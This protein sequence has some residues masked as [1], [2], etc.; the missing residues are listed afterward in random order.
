MSGASTMPL[1]P[2]CPPTYR[3]M[4]SATDSSWNRPAP[5]SSRRRTS[6]FSSLL[7]SGPFPGRRRAA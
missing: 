4:M 1:V 7:S 3:A 2:F 6:D 5:M